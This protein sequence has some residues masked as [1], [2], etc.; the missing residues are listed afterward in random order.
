MLFFRHALEAR[1]VRSPEDFL[2][3]YRKVAGEIGA[4]VPAL[5]TVEGWIYEGRKPQRAFRP[6]VVQMLNHSI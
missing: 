3:E 2:L 6:T 1:G 5:K 4:E